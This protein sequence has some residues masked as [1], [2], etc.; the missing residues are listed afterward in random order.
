MAGSNY[1]YI[2]VGAGSAGCVLANRLS[3]DPE[4]RVL[5]LE[6]GGWDYNPLIHVPIGFGMMHKHRMH[7]W[8]YESEPEPNANNRR[9]EAMRG[10]VLGGSS[11][12]N[13]TGFTR[14][15]RGDYDR[16]AQKGCQGW[17]YADVLP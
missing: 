12:I 15:D 16:W 1:D 13:V 5:V 4:V 7:D 8:G 2:I 3:E 17:S 9:I 6:A 11:S 14:G 10:K